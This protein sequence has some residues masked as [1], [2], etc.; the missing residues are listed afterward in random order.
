MGVEGMPS[1]LIIGNSGAAR[2]C[3]WLLR[4]VMQQQGDLSFKG[5][6]SF[7][8]Y[9]GEL[10]E[11]SDLQLGVDDTY[12][13]VADDV[14]V[15]GIG[16]PD[17]RMKA[18][19][20]WKERGAEFFTLVHPVCTIQSGVTLGEANIFAC[21]SYISCNTSLGSA[22]YFNGSVVVG[23]DVTLGDANFFAPFSFVGGDVRIGSRNS[24]GV[25]STV[26]AKARIGNDNTIAPGAF[27]YKGCRNNTIMSGNPALDISGE[28]I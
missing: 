18:F 13:P 20:K 8:G 1:V 10:R 21:A 15:I 23:H 14:F 17:L 3:Y 4:D 25:R 28:H 24:F 12:V 27:V 2:E 26:L 6:L 11:L 19:C 22:N 16:A 7:E 5:F 9:L